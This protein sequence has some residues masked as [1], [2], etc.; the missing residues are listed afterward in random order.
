M[1]KNSPV[2][3][4]CL[5]AHKAAA[6]HPFT[7]WRY[8]VRQYDDGEVSTAFVSQNSWRD[9]DFKILAEFQ[10][11]GGQAISEEEYENTQADEAP[12][13]IE[14]MLESNDDDYWHEEKA[15]MSRGEVESHEDYLRMKG[16]DDEA[17]EEWSRSYEGE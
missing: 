1:N 16:R 14:D 12:A 17:D 6:T 3:K 4:A 15:L 5:E 8:E 10:T 9:G 2:M 11:W 7:G 13:W